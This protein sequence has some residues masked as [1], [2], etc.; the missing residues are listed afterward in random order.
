MI[1]GAFTAAQL[2]ILIALIATIGLLTM[3]A[4]GLLISPTKSGRLW[5]FAFLAGL[6]AAGTVSVAI[7]LDMPGLSSVGYAAG[8]IVP[9]FVWAGLRARRGVPSMGGWVLALGVLS[10]GVYRILETVARGVLDDIE[11]MGG[12]V[13]SMLF[14]V[15]IHVEWRKSP[16]RPNAIMYPLMYGTSATI[17]LL[18]L[19]VFMRIAW[20][21][22]VTT[23][24]VSP[25]NV[26]LIATAVFLVSAL[27]SLAG[28]AI[29]G[30]SYEALFKGAKRNFSATAEGRLAAARV[31]DEQQWSFI[32]F[33][34]DDD[35]SVRAAVGSSTTMEIGDRL[36]E[37]V[38]A[39]FPSWADV[40]R[41][42]PVTVQVLCPGA[43]AK[44][45][46]FVKQALDNITEIDARMTLS[47]QVSASAGWTSAASEGYDLERLRE[48]A[49]ENLRVAEA[50]GGDRWERS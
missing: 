30:E 21:P 39:A 1:T 38:S 22:A 24:L 23:M 17:A 25:A 7:L 47:V 19:S 20:G 32:M 13:V 3:G 12:S 16:E 4:F 14:C 45:R 28:F 43:T 40:G 26:E 18:V 49:C 8:S 44:I 34:L 27:V 11:M 9:G 5:V 42:D 15:L 35:S 36:E 50:A 41:A 31:K 29:P 37:R 6:A 48:V 10:V 33:R 46:Q 2:P